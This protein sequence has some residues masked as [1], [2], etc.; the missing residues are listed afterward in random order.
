MPMACR[1][2]LGEMLCADFWAAESSFS[3]PV[4][5]EAVAGAPNPEDSQS[6]D[7]AKFGWELFCDGRG[8]ARVQF[9]RGFRPQRGRYSC[10]SIL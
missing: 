1:D 9:W 5:N 4:W 6:R 3:T 8:V 7:C 2:V 10:R